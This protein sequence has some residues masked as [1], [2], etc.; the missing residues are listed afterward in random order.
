[1]NSIVRT[2]PAVAAAD[3]H[4]PHFRLECTKHSQA[5]LRWAFLLNNKP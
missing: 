4:I 1:M 5:V 2:D 3:V